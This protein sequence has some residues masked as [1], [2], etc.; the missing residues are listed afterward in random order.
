MDILGTGANIVSSLATGAFNSALAGRNAARDRAENFA[1]SE[2]AAEHADLRARAQWRDM[3]SI[4]AQLQQLKE[5]GLSPSLMYSSIPGSQGATGAQGQGAGGIQ[6]P[7][8]PIDFAQAQLLAAEAR[9]ANAEADKVEG[10]NAGGQADIALKLAQAG[11]AKAA[12]EYTKA[13]KTWQDFQNNILNDTYNDQVWRI[14]SEARRAADEAQTAYWEAENAGL[15]FHFNLENY[16]TELQKSRQTLANLI[17]SEKLSKAEC[18]KIATEIETMW[19]NALANE[20]TAA[21]NT[22]NADAYANYVEAFCDNLPKQ[23]ELRGKELNVEKWRIGVGAFTETM[24]TIGY[25]LGAQQLGDGGTQTTQTI[26]DYDKKGRP[27][28]TRTTNT[29][30]VRLPKIK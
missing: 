15:Q 16:Q 25:F 26:Q 18:N 28:H 13:Q 14:K 4:Q 3:Y 7:F 17:Q 6:T 22:A 19:V 21:A 27:T 12:T 9:K 8:T 5:A 1:Y 24:R 23:L 2:L 10:K 30:N 11:A 29:K 20:E